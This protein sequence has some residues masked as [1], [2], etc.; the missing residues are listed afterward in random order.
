MLKSMTGFGRYEKAFS[1]GRVI[2]EVHSVNR[3]YFEASIFLPK[4][5]LRF[6]VTIRKWLSQN[7]ARGNVSLRVYIIPQVND[8]AS[9]LPSK[10]LLTILKDKWTHLLHDIG[11]DDKQIDI[12]FLLQQ[13]KQFFSSQDIDEKI[14]EEALKEGVS[15]AVAALDVMRKDEGKI[16]VEDFKA[17][18]KVIDTILKE[19]ESITPQFVEKYRDKLKAKLI[20]LLPEQLDNDDRIFRE[21][22]IFAEKVDIAEEILR[23]K[24]HLYQFNKLID[25]ANSSIGRKLD[26]LLQ[27]MN[28]EINTIA[29]KSFNDAIATYV[30]TVKSELEKIREQ[31]QNIE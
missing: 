21:A 25:E 15:S 27:E 26:F 7:I 9:F 19:I 18:T 6:D 3:K 1:F 20:E 4:E 13:N 31:V 10:E 17:R 11:L 24:S 16:I 8:S 2:V 14:Y 22:A 30:V 28:R 29:S 5:I 12:D 23:F